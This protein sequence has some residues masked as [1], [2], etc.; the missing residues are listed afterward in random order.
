MEQTYI[1]AIIHKADI[2]KAIGNPLRLCMLGKLC[3]QKEIN[4]TDMKEC[5]GASQPLIS[6]NLRKLKDL[7][8]VEVRK[9]GN[10]SYYSIGSEDFRQL[11]MMIL[12]WG[13]N[14]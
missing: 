4:V 1:D 9:D 12:E 8:I 5:T 7:G 10:N 2:L 11:V 3:E 14:E 13:K 6:Q